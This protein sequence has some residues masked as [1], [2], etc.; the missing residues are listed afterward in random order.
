MTIIADTHCH[1]NHSHDASDTLESMCEEAVGKGLKVLCTSEHIFLDHRDVGY[2]YFDLEA[3]LAEVAR[4]RVLFRG[5]LEVLSGVEFSETHLYPE[6]FKLMNK[7]PI[8]MLVG[9]LHWLN[10]GFFGSP[11]VL[12]SM[13]KDT[14]I[15]T[16]YE[17]LYKMVSIG[18]FDTLAHMDLLKRY[19]PIDEANVSEPMRKVLKSLV[20]QNIALELNTSTIRKDQCQPAASYALVDAYLKLGGQRLTVGSDAHCLKDI[21]GDFDKIPRRYLPFIGYF[22][23]R[24]F[25]YS[26]NDCNES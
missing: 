23:K 10:K 19:I 26:Q 17:E 4:C 2:G 25:V 22:R 24:V 16:Y 9:A 1:S 7:A 12:V 21:G 3:Y 14:L 15:Q 13:T 11:K 20:D 5:Q 8:D 18:G 6:A